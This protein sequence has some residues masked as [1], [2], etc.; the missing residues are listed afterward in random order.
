[1]NESDLAK[2]I[3]NWFKNNSNN[4]NKWNRSPVG[5]VIKQSLNSLNNWKNAPRGN[6]A[7]GYRKAMEN[8][9]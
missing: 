2:E 5:I 9:Y 8:K 1:M 7:K 6:P 4:P 3:E